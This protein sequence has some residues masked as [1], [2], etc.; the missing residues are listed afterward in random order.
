L[1]ARSISFIAAFRLQDRFLFGSD[2]PFFMPQRWLKD[3]DALDYFKPEVREKLLWKNGQ[4][5]LAHLAIGKM[6]FV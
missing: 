6:K 1:I 2:Y 5:L 4:K 3:F